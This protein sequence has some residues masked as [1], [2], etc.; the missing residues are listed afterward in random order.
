MQMYINADHM[1]FRFSVN[2]DTI[3]QRSWVQVK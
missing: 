3:G 2:A 1:W